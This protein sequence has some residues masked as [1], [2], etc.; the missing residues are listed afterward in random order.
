MRKIYL[1]YLIMRV[2]RKISYIAFKKGLTISELF[3][4]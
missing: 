1:K 2:R 4:K 3:F